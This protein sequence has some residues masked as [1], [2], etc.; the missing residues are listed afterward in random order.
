MED[1]YY[2]GMGMCSGFVALP[3]R[4]LISLDELENDRITIAEIEEL[5]HRE[6]VTDMKS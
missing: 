4:A 1:K 5:L 6:E 3:E 2:Q